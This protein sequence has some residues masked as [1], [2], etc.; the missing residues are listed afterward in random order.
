MGGFFNKAKGLNDWPVNHLTDLTILVNFNTWPEHHQWPYSETSN[1]RSVP[2]A[3][4]MQNQSTLTH[5]VNKLWI[6]FGFVQPQTWTV[7][8]PFAIIWDVV[9]F[10]KFFCVS[11]FLTFWLLEPH[12][13]GLVVFSTE[14]HIPAVKRK[15]IANRT[16]E[17]SVKLSNSE[18]IFLNNLQFWDGCTVELLVNYRG[19]KVAKR[20]IEI[21]YYIAHW[22]CSSIYFQRCWTF[23]GQR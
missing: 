14:T 10:M 8:L 12:S 16:N 13:F 21:W 6:D 5:L 1:H 2:L 3:I 23:S 22:T 7:V 11:Y 9:V 20:E 4:P 18:W 19:N 15:A 17:Q